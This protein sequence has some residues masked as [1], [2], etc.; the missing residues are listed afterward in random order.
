[1]FTEPPLLAEGA[2]AVTVLSGQPL[3]IPCM[4]LDGIPLPE[5][6]WTHNGKQVSNDETHAEDL[7]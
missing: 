1:M 7:C 2:P 5:R 6:V 4:L 3:H